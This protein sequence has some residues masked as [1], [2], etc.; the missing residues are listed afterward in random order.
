MMVVDERKKAEFKLFN[1]GANLFGDAAAIA[2][3]EMGWGIDRNEKGVVSGL[4]HPDV[5]IEGVKAGFTKAGDL[6][7]SVPER[8]I[9]SLSGVFEEMGWDVIQLEPKQTVSLN[10]NDRND[11]VTVYGKAAE[12]IAQQFSLPL[13]KTD[14]GKEKVSFEKPEMAKVSAFLSSRG[15]RTEEK[16]VEHS[17]PPKATIFQR[18]L[19]D[20]GERFYV[21]DNSARNVAKALGIELLQTPGGR[22][23]LEFDEQQYGTIKKQL[24]AQG[25][26]LSQKDLKLTARVATYETPGGQGAVIIGEPAKEAAALMGKE[27]TWTRPSSR[28]QSLPMLRLKGEDEIEAA[29]SALEG[30]GYEIDVQELPSLANKAI[31]KVGD[32]QALLFGEPAEVVAEQL[33]LELSTAQNGNSMLRV[34][35]EQLDDA[36][37]IL[38]GNDYEVKREPL[39][40]PRSPQSSRD[41]DAQE[42]ATDASVH[43][44]SAPKTAVNKK[45]KDK[46]VVQPQA[47]DEDVV[48]PQAKDAT[49]KPELFSPDQI[50][51][52]TRHLAL[53]GDVS[54]KA[55]AFADRI[56]GGAADT[57]AFKE[58]SEFRFLRDDAGC[59]AIQD[60]QG[61]ELGRSLPTGQFQWSDSSVAQ[62]LARRYDAASVLGKS[63]IKK[64]PVEQER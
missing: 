41:S 22:P 12:A 47:K 32:K 51:Q 44:R 4:T 9:P 49:A 54:A 27:T 29:R 2:C 16:M 35:L 8:Y 17:H 19:P 18:E 37:D 31:V 60:K 11:L 10:V 59:I 48:Q 1:G 57:P 33:D 5:E 53:Q 26:D 46:D 21:F 63:L 58:G 30:L 36:I 20:G 40:R 14:S 38:E 15:Y 3:K 23:T 55:F 7:I 50:R 25:F 42:Q 52:Q 28:G 45:K 56:L 34:P 13:E 64:K 24:K 39:T 62:D 61:T 6:Y 43:P